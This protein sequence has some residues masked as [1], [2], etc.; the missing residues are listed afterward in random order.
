MILS[1]LLLSSPLLAVD[2]EMCMG[3]HRP[4]SP[5]APNL[6]GM[7]VDHFVA[8]MMAYKTGER[9]DPTMKALAMALNDADIAGLAAYFRALAD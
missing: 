1:S 4:G 2:P 9:P 5:V 6:I 3:C 8:A 7:P